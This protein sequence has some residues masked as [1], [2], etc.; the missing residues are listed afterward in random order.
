MQIF[1]LNIDAKMRC[2]HRIFWGPKVH[3]G[4]LK[5][6]EELLWKSGPGAPRCPVAPRQV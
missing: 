3:F 4:K 2:G 1:E 5:Y 6:I